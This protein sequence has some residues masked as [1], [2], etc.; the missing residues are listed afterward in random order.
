M[1][2]LSVRYETKQEETAF[3]QNW[4]TFSKSKNRLAELEVQKSSAKVRL[5]TTETLIEANRLKREELCQKKE[6]T[7]SILNT[8]QDMKKQSEEMSDKADILAS[9][10]LM[11]KNEGKALA[12]KSATLLQ[13]VHRG[14]QQVQATREQQ[15][16][17]MLEKLERCISVLK[18]KLDNFSKLNDSP[19]NLALFEHLNALIVLGGELKSEIQPTRI[20][21]GSVYPKLQKFILDYNGVVAKL[22]KI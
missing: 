22:K 20:A 14:L 7:Q 16:K 12:E 15:A 4:E 10:A 13:D 21:I 11:L 1:Q 18:S 9:Q 5:A 19:E 6:N 3:K 2:S 8:A 17:A